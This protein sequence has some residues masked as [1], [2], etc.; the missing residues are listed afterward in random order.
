MSLE[1]YNF[2]LVEWFSFFDAQYIYNKHVIMGI[3]YPIRSVKKK[4]GQFLL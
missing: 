3:L 1:I 2:L 4:A